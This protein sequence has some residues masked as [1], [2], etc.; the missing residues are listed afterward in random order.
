M[1]VLNNEDIEGHIHQE[2]LDDQ[3]RRVGSTQSFV[4]R[5]ESGIRSRER[6]HE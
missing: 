6:E 3:K 4:G 2:G 5:E 1:G